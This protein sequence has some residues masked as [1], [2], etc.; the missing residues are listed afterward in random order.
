MKRTI[1]L[2]LLF[3]STI[4]TTG[5]QGRVYDFSLKNL[6]QRMVSLSDIQGEELTVIDFWATWCQPCIR[7]L[8]KIV[9]MSKDFEDSGVRFVGISVDSPRNISKIKPFTRSMGITYPVLLDPSGE[10][11]GEL[12]VMAVPTLLIVDGDLNIVYTHEGF[13]AG[14]EAIVRE[15]IEKYLE[16]GIH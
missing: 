13:N 8:P 6:D 9:E 2:A 12:N 14:D 11:M 1:I 10:L 15:E 16:A 3:S 5:F 4:M 7:S